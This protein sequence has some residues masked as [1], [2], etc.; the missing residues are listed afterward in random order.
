MHGGPP[1]VL[2]V[3]GVLVLGCQVPAHGLLQQGSSTC[4]AGLAPKALGTHWWDTGG[5]CVSLPLQGA[6]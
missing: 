1:R 4:H 6:C 2:W 5:G 3:V